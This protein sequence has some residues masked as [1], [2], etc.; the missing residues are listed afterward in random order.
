MLEKLRLP[1]MPALLRA[2]VVCSAKPAT[3]TAT[4]KSAKPAAKPMQ[5]A[6]AAAAAV[7][8]MTAPMAIAEEK[9]KVGD[10]YTNGA[11]RIKPNTQGQAKCLANC[12]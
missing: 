8:L 11:A 4:A 6:A 1:K 5:F 10:T 9:P 12:S 3:K 7:M 2:P